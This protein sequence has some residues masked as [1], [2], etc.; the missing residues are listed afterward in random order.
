MATP[1]RSGAFSLGA[2]TSRRV[3]APRASAG[4]SAPAAPA[5][6]PARPV[7]ALVKTIA[8]R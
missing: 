4:A 5:N 8:W 1:T 6:A 2:Y 7:R 3:C